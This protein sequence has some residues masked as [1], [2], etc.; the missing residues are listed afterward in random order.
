MARLHDWWLSAVAAIAVSM[1]NPARRLGRP[2]LERAYDAYPPCAAAAAADRAEALQ[3]CFAGLWAG[4]PWLR[5][6]VGCLSGAPVALAALAAARRLYWQTTLLIQYA[7]VF[8]RAARNPPDDGPPLRPVQALHPPAMSSSGVR[9]GR[10]R[11]RFNRQPP[12]GTGAPLDVAFTHSG[13]EPSHRDAYQCLGRP[14]AG[15]RQGQTGV[16]QP[17]PRAQFACSSTPLQWFVRPIA[18]ASPGRLCGGEQQRPVS[19]AGQRRESDGGVLCCIKKTGAV[20]G[21]CQHT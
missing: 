13:I 4:W 17:L 12:H 19:F 14:D 2:L 21:C 10:C 5:R 11:S 6:L 8:S 1:P 9:R 18:T 20:N 15:R 16:L 3:P 7:L